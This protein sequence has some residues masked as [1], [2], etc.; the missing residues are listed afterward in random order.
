MDEQRAVTGILLGRASAPEQAAAIAQTYRACPYCASYASSGD[1]VF[2]LF[3]LP[4]DHR[5]WLEWVEEHPAE[6]LGLRQAEV[7]FARQVRVASPWSRGEVEPLLERAPC[8]A[9]CAGCPRYR[10]GCEGCPATSGWRGDGA[11][12]G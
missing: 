12:G 11:A 2:G 4:S 7:F 5:W 9:E 3:S 1:T 10:H 8:G 6:T